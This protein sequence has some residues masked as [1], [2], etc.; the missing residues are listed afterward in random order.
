[1]VPPFFLEMPTPAATLPLSNLNGISIV[2]RS[3]FVAKKTTKLR[4]NRQTGIPF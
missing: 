3:I 2:P 1:M 4:K